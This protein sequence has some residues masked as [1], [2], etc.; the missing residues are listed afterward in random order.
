MKEL[1][2]IEESIIIRILKMWDLYSFV[3]T[4]GHSVFCTKA[5]VMIS[6]LAYSSFSVPFMVV[7]VQ[8]G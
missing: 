3:Y 1:E 5:L 6:N 4:S 8:Y 7:I 2:T